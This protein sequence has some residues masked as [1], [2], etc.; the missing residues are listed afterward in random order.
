MVGVAIVVGGPP[1]PIAFE[2]PMIE[3]FLQAARQA[4][5]LD[6]PAP[7]AKVTVQVH[8][9]MVPLFA[10]TVDGLDPVAG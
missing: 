4:R 9:P 1:P 5:P 6:V 7:L 3:T 10:V 8:P 2:E